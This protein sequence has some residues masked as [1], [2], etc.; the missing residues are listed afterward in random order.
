MLSKGKTS[1]EKGFFGEE[2]I[3]KMGLGIFG[4]IFNQY[5]I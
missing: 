3:K 5:D 1:R 2:H 4:G